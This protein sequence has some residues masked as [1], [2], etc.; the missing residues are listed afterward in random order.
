MQNLSL[1][2]SVQSRVNAWLTGKYDDTTKAEIQ[3]LIDEK[4]TTEIRHL[5]LKY[6]ESQSGEIIFGLSQTGIPLR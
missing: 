3:L 1:E 6:F 2:P 5:P 4:N